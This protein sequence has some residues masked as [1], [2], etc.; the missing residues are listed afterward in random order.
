MCL[1]WSLGKQ[2]LGSNTI[3]ALDVVSNFIPQPTL[4]D[5]R[6]KVGLSLGGE[7]HMCML[8]KGFYVTEC[9]TDQHRRHKLLDSHLCLGM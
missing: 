7:N 4:K 5:K 8:E 3:L 9:W 2:N 1:F 6:K